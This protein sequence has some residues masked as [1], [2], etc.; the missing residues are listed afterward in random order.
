MLGP[1]DH[2]QVVLQEGQ[3]VAIALARA[4]Q[5]PH[6]AQVAAVGGEVAL[7]QHVLDVGMAAHDPGAEER[8]A[9]D[10]PRL[11]QAPVG[12]V[13][14]APLLGQPGVPGADQEAEPAHEALAGHESLDDAERRRHGKTFPRRGR[15][16]I[17]EDRCGAH[18]AV[19]ARGE[20]GA[21]SVYGISGGLRW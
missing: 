14:V 5:E 2:E 17:G 18:P 19:S 21:A 1:V 4:A 3:Q 13:G 8:G 15:P 7:A 16:R 20:A 9:R 12:R 11:A 10:R 6:H